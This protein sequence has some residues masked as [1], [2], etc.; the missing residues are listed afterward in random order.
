MKFIA[1]TAALALMAAAASP[2][3]ATDFT[4]AYSV[5]LNT[6]ESGLTL[7][8]SGIAPSLSFTLTP[9]DP[10]ASNVDLF[11]LFTKET[12]VNRDDLAPQQISV[13][14]TFSQP[15]NFTDSVGGTTEGQKFIFGLFQDGKVTW[16]SS[17]AVDIGNGEQLEISLSDATFNDGVF[18][19]RP[20]QK[21]G[22]QIEGTFTLIPATASAVPEPATWAV[23][24]TGFGGL[25]VAMRRA[26]RKLAATT[27]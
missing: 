18:G 14:F 17:P 24:L 4:T 22:A 6:N 25:G 7:H 8:D 3:F 21:Y 23:M 16:D 13:D 19:L 11:D 15:T 9:T 10:T 20:G 12:T 26:R 27:A 1:Q 5:D 2:A